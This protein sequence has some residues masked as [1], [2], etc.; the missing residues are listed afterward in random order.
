MSPRKPTLT[1]PENCI[2]RN[3]D[4]TIHYGACH[5]GCG[6]ITTIAT[7]TNCSQ[8]TWAGMPKKFVAGHHRR[9]IRPIITQPT[10]S[11]IRLIALTQGKIAKVD[12]KNYESL[13][14]TYWSAWKNID[15][16]KFYARTN[17]P[18]RLGN[19][20]VLMHLLVLPAPRGMLIDHIDRDTLNNIEANLRI[21]TT[22]Q[23]NMNHKK[24]C[25]NTSGATG[26]RLHLGKYDAAIRYN[27]KTIRLGRFDLFEDAIQARR[28]K[29]IELFGEFS[30]VGRDDEAND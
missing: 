5:C 4:C 19:G 10:D 21:S 17:L 22:S 12:A 3:P 13:V 6:E 8:G 14:R 16:G 29:E 20:V 1:Q 24:Y 28:T 26:I 9:H 27:Y 11:E 30:R 2:C 18:A 15:T 25:T 23:N 7:L